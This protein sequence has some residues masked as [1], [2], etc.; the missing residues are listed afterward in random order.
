MFVILRVEKHCRVTGRLDFAAVL[1]R[2][3][4]TD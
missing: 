3:R 2:R 1:V 4:N